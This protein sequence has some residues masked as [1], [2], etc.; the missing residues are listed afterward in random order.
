MEK[1][2]NSRSTLFNPGIDKAKA[3]DTGL[4][5]VLIF[6]ILEWWLGG[7]FYLKFSIGILIL[8][9]TVPSLF[10]PLAYVWFGFAHIMGTIVSKILLFLIFIF[11]VVPVGLFRKV[12]GKD[13]LQLKNWKS[14]KD[15]VF[16]TRNHP[17]SANDIEKPF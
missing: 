16:F 17:F 15:S 4:A 14:S 9:M 2:K 8:D 7:G 6:L 10:K 5:I 1:V 3:R 13:T 12:L 11:I